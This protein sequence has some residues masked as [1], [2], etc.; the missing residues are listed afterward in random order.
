MKTRKMN[1]TGCVPGQTRELNLIEVR[2]ISVKEGCRPGVYVIIGDNNKIIY[3]GSSIEVRNRCDSHISYFNNNR[4]AKNLQALYDNRKGDFSY[5]IVEFCEKQ[6]LYIKEKELIDFIGLHRLA[7]KTGIVKINKIERNEE[8]AKR[9]GNIRSDANFKANARKV[10]IAREIY[11]LK[12]YAK[13]KVSVDDVVA[14]YGLKS[15]NNY[16]G[17]GKHKYSYLKPE[18]AK[19]PSWF[20][21][22]DNL[23]LF[24]M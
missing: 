22:V 13:D 2:S 7:N 14:I 20:D 21:Y 1:L 4:Q 15:K 19:K 11:W 17:V 5:W 8:E 16:H 12:L 18:N 10:E 3:V 9:I 24:A 6:E 23:G